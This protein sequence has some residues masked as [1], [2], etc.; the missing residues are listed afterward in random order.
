MFSRA[1]ESQTHPHFFARENA[2]PDNEPQAPTE[3]P[4]NA[5]SESGNPPADAVAPDPSELARKLAQCEA[6]L[7]ESFARARD[8]QA[9]LKDEHERLL[10]T[11]AEFENYKRRATKEKEDA[12]KFAAEALLKDFLPVADNLERALDHLGQHDPA[13]VAEGV[14]LVQKMLES[15]LAKHGVVSFSAVGQPFDP[16]Q[17]EALMQAESDAPSNTVIQEMARGY[18]L[19]DRLV[20]PAAVVVAK[21]RE[22]APRPGAPPQSEGNGKI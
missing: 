3:G 11:A 22:A 5:E 20:R 13:A 21:P 10:R 16:S 9:K 19:H 15:A 2:L 1:L 18:R 8:G 17:H 4:G 12:R 14:K 7:E 6:Q